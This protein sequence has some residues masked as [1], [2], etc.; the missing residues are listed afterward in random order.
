MDTWILLDGSERSSIDDL[1]NET[2]DKLM[3]TKFLGHVV[4]RLG[5]S[6][7]IRRLHRLIFLAEGFEYVKFRL[8]RPSLRPSRAS[9]GALTC[10]R[11]RKFAAR[12]PAVL[13]ISMEEPG[14]SV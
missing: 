7:Q 14:Y 5:A 9:S 4:W 11:S 13:K 10:H 3:E 2:L 12:L 1:I 8:F 6:T